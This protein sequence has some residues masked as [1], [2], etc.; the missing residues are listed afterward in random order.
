[1]LKVAIVGCGKIAD[2]HASQIQR[3]KGCE[4]VGVC[5]REWLMA[6]QLYERFPVKQY[7]T[8][9][10]KLL[11]D[12]RPDVVHITTPPESHFEIARCCLE[13]G[14]HVYVEKPFTLHEKEAQRLVA[15]AN[16]KGLKLTAGHDDQFSHVARRM[17]ALVQSGY[18]GGGPVHMES[19]Y[20]YDLGEHGYAQAL[21]GDKH[22]W[23]R[24]LPGKLLQYVIGHG[25]AR[26]AEFL[27][28]DSPQVIAYGFVSP[29]L[30]RMGESEIIDELRV[31]ICEEER[32]TAYFTFS[33]QMRPS[34]HQFRVYGH[35]N[36][37][38]LDQDQETLIKLRGGRFK[39]YAEKFIPPV[40]FAEQHLGNLIRNVRTFLAMDFHMKSGM[41]YLIESF[42]RSI[43]QGTPV[44]IPYREILLTAR[45][46]DAIF[47][48]LA[49]RRSQVHFESNIQKLTDALQGTDCI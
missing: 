39:S 21:L 41:K 34:I 26:I 19:Y 22:H 10:P 49:A 35:K 32:T 1:M 15:L 17:R 5:D 45:I 7:F 48:Q 9:L 23:V 14:C 37:L 44:P 24:R 11:S 20:C 33:S 3:I 12:A 8:D 42:Y 31:I 25:I 6:R 2:A 36:G 43:I 29:L 38:V 4:I 27:T 30:K 13:R 28:S 16:E 40:I 47:D 46:M 18:L